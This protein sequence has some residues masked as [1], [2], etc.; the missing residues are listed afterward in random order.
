MPAIVAV[1]ALLITVLSVM[2]TDFVYKRE[3][4]RRPSPMLLMLITAW[5][6]G[7]YG[8]TAFALLAH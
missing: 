4:N 5:F 3:T 1:A 8:L 7:I 2:L 6:L